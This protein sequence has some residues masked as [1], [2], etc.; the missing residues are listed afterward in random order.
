MDH[1]ELFLFIFSFL[2]G[3]LSYSFFYWTS[4]LSPKVSSYCSPD[5]TILFEQPINNEDNTNN[6]ELLPLPLYQLQYIIDEFK[7]WKV[8]AIPKASGSDNY[9]QLKP[10]QRSM[11]DFN[12]NECHQRNYTII[13]YN[14]I[15]SVEIDSND[16]NL[17][18][19][20]NGYLFEYPGENISFVADVS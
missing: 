5:P 16:D 18:T 12:F 11:R 19:C 17:I 13:N 15:K 9:Y 20:T 6:N 14:G 3:F 10:E 1:Q 4:Y 7:E 8:N 2:S